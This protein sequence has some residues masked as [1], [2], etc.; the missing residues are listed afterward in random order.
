MQ[1]YKTREMCKNGTC[2]IVNAQSS[3]FQYF[4]EKLYANWEESTFTIFDRFLNTNSSYLDVGAWIGP[5][6][7]YGAQKAEHVYAI[8]PDP[9]AYQE[10]T[11]NLQLNP[12]LTSKERGTP[13]GVGSVTSFKRTL[14]PFSCSWNFFI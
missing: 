13:Y 7:L 4:W 14:A 8:E 1:N 5:T 11:R 2:F 12:S 9:V 3:L 10:L 6:I